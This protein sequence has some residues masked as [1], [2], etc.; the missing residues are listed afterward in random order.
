MLIDN[1]MEKEGQGD[2]TE[3]VQ[4]HLRRQIR[5]VSLAWTEI[6]NLRFVGSPRLIRKDPYQTEAHT[7]NVGLTSLGQ[8]Q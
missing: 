2:V 3:G 4:V 1:C 5:S 7:R 8:I 6:K